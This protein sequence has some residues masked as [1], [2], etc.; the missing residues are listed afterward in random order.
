MHTVRRWESR[1]NLYFSL[2]AAGNMLFFRPKV[3][4]FCIHTK[5]V[6]LPEEAGVCRAAEDVFVGGVRW[7]EILYL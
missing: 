2:L 4:I 3:P 6:I 1:E 7:E 5:H